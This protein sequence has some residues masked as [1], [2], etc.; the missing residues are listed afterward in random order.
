[1]KI[2][3]I[4]ITGNDVDPLVVDVRKLQPF[5]VQEHTSDQLASGSL[6]ILSYPFITF[7]ANIRRPVPHD[8]TY[9]KK[10]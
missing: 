7:P 6:F 2:T 4:D 1:M 5:F 10:C 3:I 8:T 9:N